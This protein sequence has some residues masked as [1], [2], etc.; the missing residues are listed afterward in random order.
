[1]EANTDPQG[2]YLGFTLAHNVA[3]KEHVGRVLREAEAAGATLVKEAQDVFWG[4]HSGYFADPNG[5]Q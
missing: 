1:M 4:G 5:H 3:E 2:G